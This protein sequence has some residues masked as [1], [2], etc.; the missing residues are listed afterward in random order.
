MDGGWHTS[1][2][3]RYR[4]TRTTTT[5][6]DNANNN[7]KSYQKNK[8]IQ[9]QGPFSLSPI[10]HRRSNPPKTILFKQ[11]NEQKL[12]RYGR[13]T[14]LLVNH[15]ISQHAPD[16]LPISLRLAIREQ[17][18]ALNASII[19]P[20]ISP[21]PDDLIVPHPAPTI[22]P[23]AATNVEDPTNPIA[24]ENDNNTNNTTQSIKSHYAPELTNYFTTKHN[25]QRAVLHASNQ[26]YREKMIEH[27][28]REIN[29]TRD[30]V[31]HT[32]GTWKSTLRHRSPRTDT[33][34]EEDSN[35][36]LTNA[37]AAL[38][39]KAIQY[40]YL[41]GTQVL[42]KKAMYTDSYKLNEYWRQMDEQRA[43]GI[44]KIAAKK[45][46]KLPKKLSKSRAISRSFYSPT[47][48]TNETDNEKQ[49]EE[50]DLMKERTKSIVEY[51]APETIREVKSMLDLLLHVVWRVENYKKLWA[52]AK[53]KNNVTVVRLK[54]IVL[55]LLSFKLK[56][57]WKKWMDVNKYIQQTS[58][59]RMKRALSISQI[60]PTHWRRELIKQLCLKRFSSCLRVVK[61]RNAFDKWKDISM[62]YDRHLRDERL[63]N[64]LLFQTPKIRTNTKKERSMSS[65][66]SMSKMSKMSKMSSKS[67]QYSKRRLSIREQA[68]RKMLDTINIVSE[69]RSTHIY[70]NTGLSAD[71]LLDLALGF[72][73]NK[74]KMHRSLQKI[75]S[76]SYF[77]NK[78][79]S[80]DLR[81]RAKAVHAQSGRTWYT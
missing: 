41:P 59:R 31:R 51:P 13:S 75:P 72:K 9:Q 78:A 18:D 74:N 17:S 6:S 48:N 2:R 70:K 67:K 40:S 71:E 44:T 64:V 76:K 35:I 22:T 43:L 77:L 3:K 60:R 28:V 4:R 42:V 54:E 12:N 5:W 11:T 63:R 27:R 61:V 30:I 65:M 45:E 68:P 7:V 24:L 21:Y 47:Q 62:N 52:I 50:M 36:K 29:L 37:D 25:N 19:I 73:K 66:S 34:E 10:K 38:R 32:N 14:A 33:E 8:T 16:L 55:Y 53:L 49:T 39:L 57:A 15:K 46:I 23:V 81:F 58:H 80:E 69:K 20:T 56:K 1:P 79:K 26:L